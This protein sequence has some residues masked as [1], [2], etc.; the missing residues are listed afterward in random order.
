MEQAVD[1]IRMSQFLATIRTDVPIELD[2]DALKITPP[3]AAR[4]TEI[5]AELEF[6]SLADKILNKEK[7]TVKKVNPQL[8]LFSENAPEGQEIAE[9]KH[10]QSIKNT[11]HEYKLIETEEEA[12]SLLDFF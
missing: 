10:S 11:P 7:Q 6:K 8:D 12:R 9:N 5:F 1:D 3:D 4:L 2:L